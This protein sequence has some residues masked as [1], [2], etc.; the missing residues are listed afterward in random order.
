MSP[1]GEVPKEDFLRDLRFGMADKELME[2]YRLTARGLGTLFRNLVNAEVISFRELIRIASGQLN[3]PE[4]VAELRIRSRKQLEFMLPISDAEDPEN[5]GLVYDISDDG[6]G[7]RGLKAKMHEIRT[8]VIPADDFFRVEP[9]VFEG[10]CRWIDE[11]GDRWE[12]AAGF[13]VT[14]LLRGS[15]TE[16]QEIIRALHPETHGR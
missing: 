15:L 1:K 9:V 16:L 14:K 13:R 7:T 5:A 12:S 6:V 10:V 2:K 4:M 3:L 11:K 8:L